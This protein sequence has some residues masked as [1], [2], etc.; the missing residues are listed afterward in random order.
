MSYIQPTIYPII[1]QSSTYA[2]LPTDYMVKGD[3]TSTAFTVT[4]PTAVG[5]SGKAYIVKNVGAKVL[6]IATTSAQTIDGTTTYG[7]KIQYTSV[8]V[9]S[10][11]ANWLII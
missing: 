3:T 2:V 1:T 9:A 6:T 10:D 4:L 11:G 5:V 7:L 8:T